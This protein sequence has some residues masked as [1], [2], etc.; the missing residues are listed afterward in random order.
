MATRRLTS[1][2]AA[3]AA[4]IL[5]T[6]A[7]SAA[8]ARAQRWQQIG[9]GAMNISDQV[10]L[11]RTSDGVLHVAWRRGAAAQELLQTSITAA[12]TVRAPLSVVS[13]W[14][15]VGS[16]ALVAQG[17]VL[18]AFF[19]GTP[20]L[21]T[22]DPR[23]GLDL[24]RSPGAA[25]AWMVNP[26]AIAQ[27]Q[28]SGAST[29]AAAV[30]PSGSSLQAWHAPEGTVVHVG[31]DP[32][33]PAVG[34]Y[35]AGTDQA[36]ATTPDG[37]AKVAWC[38]NLG[39]RTGVFVAGVDPAGGTRIGAPLLL[40]QTG[41]CPA[42]TR[43]ALAAPRYANPFKHVL[44]DPH[45]Y[46]WDSFLVAASDDSG[47]RVRLF[48]VTRDTRDFS[49]YNLW[50]GPTVSTGQSFKQ[51]IALALAPQYDGGIWLGWYDSDSGGLVF[52]H[53][54][55]A[56]DWGAAVSVALPAHGSISQ[57][58]LDAQDDRV[59]VV[60]RVADAENRVGLFATQVR[61]GLT[62]E[63]GSRLGIKRRGFH[64]LDANRA[65]GRA[66]VRVAG[67]TLTTSASG[68]A[69]ADLP[70]GAYRATASKAGYVEATLRIQLR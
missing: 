9:S 70:P 49:R 29:P 20:T 59:D 12:G 62:L 42:D 54:F 36:L 34:G 32:A 63:A 43:V 18:S 67:R 40:P 15:T 27:S 58:Q 66:T 65:V 23:F 22:G 61:P 50:T 5:L 48:Q 11:A 14:A 6:V 19:P 41:R 21:V 45:A 39:A 44:G 31:L 55:N 60:A 8:A 68:F 17:Q 37:Q 35:G 56:I 38:T 1:A 2:A 33:V 25:T 69:K 26:T 10:G 47:R 7:G 4:A 51:Q 30:T 3:V 13:G 24:A 57:L 28:F 16:P 53:S 52:R 46:V 64:V